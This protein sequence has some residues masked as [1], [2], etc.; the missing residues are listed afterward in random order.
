MDIDIDINHTEAMWSDS[1][2]IL[3]LPYQ[4]RQQI[5]NYKNYS[6][7]PSSNINSKITDNSCNRSLCDVLNTVKTD[8]RTLPSSILPGIAGVRISSACLTTARAS[9]ACAFSR[10]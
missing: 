2:D 4:Q 1:C 3:L 6:T 5:E 7:K 8:R 9:T 10:L